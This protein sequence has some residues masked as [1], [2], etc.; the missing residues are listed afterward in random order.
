MRLPAAELGQSAFTALGKPKPRRIEGDTNEFA[1][2]F[3]RSIFSRR[4]R[5]CFGATCA[6]SIRK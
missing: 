6:S 5:P 1:E 2:V 4:N 3:L